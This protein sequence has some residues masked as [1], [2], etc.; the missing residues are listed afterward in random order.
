MTD[1]AALPRRTARH[2]AAASVLAAVVVACS[3]GGRGSQT[4]SCTTFDNF[5]SPTCLSCIHGSCESQEKSASS[6]CECTCADGGANCTNA[7]SDACMN[8]TDAIQNC[9][10]QNC[11]VQCM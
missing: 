8:A 7:N 3:S 4:E 10:T 6:V 11:S 5:L 2:S 9:L 1:R